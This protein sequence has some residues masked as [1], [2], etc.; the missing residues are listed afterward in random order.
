MEGLQDPACQTRQLKCSATHDLIA[1]GICDRLANRKSNH[2]R[3]SQSCDVMHRSWHCDSNGD[4]AQQT[5][6][7]TYP[8]TWRPR[9][10]GGEFVRPQPDQDEEPSTAFYSSMFNAQTPEVCLG[11]R[12]EYPGTQSKT[13]SFGYVGV[14]HDHS[15][16]QLV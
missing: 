14:S 10:G 1:I 6:Q 11:R 16:Y 2:F 4:T 7:P 15:L 13:P 3:K 5:Y 9:C 12:E 8:V